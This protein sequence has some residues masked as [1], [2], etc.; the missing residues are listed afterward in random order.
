MNGGLRAT[1]TKRRAAAA[2]CPATGRGIDAR[3]ADGEQ[4]RHINL[5]NSPTIVLNG[6]LSSVVLKKN[7]T[8]GAAKKGEHISGAQVRPHLVLLHYVCIIYGEVALLIHAFE[9]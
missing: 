8:I 1:E 7:F 5:S 9:L 2:V 6:F 3:D 4:K